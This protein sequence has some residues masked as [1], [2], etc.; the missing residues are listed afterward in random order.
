MGRRTRF[1]FWL[2]LVDSGA[3]VSAFQRSVAIQLGID[4]ARCRRSRMLGVGGI[5]DAYRCDIEI[6]VEG[7]RFPI[8]VSFVSEVVALLGR[9]DVFMRFVFAFDQR[10]QTLFV[11]PY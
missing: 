11:E 8:E 5:T 2:A 6:E 4:L 7:H 10:A 9:H 3:D 1:R